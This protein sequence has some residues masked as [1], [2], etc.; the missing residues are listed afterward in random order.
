MTYTPTFEDMLYLNRESP[1]LFTNPRNLASVARNYS[2]SDA[3]SVSVR[4]TAAAAQYQDYLSRGGEP[5]T[6]SPIPTPPGAM[7]ESW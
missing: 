6:E 5:L 7:R 1:E 4:E 3:V 2:G